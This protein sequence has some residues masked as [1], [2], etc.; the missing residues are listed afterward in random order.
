MS[1]SRRT[2]LRRGALAA[3]GA[4]CSPVLA[5]AAPVKKQ[6]W[7]IILNTVRNEMKVDYAGTL[8]KLAE[9]GYRYIEGGSYG[10]SEKEYGKLLRRLGLKPV[11][12]GS[13][14]SNLQESLPDYI[15]RGHA[16]NYEYITCYWPWLSSAENLTRDECLQAA[17][18]L[19]RMGRQLKGEGLRLAWHNHDKEFRP[20][21]DT[22][23]FDLLLQHTDPE[24]VTVQMDLYWVYKGGAD[25]LPYFDRYPGRFELFHVKDMDDSPERGITC[26]GEGIIDFQPIFDRAKEAGVRYSVV[27]HERVEAGLR[28]AEVSMEYLKSLKV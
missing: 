17:E 6:H 22:C 24:L 25:P 20:I 13:S 14:M 10:D 26:V 2:F 5:H 18:R 27:E 19:N 3:L 21:G 1:P 28:C 7:G 16:L 11:V 8:E 12:G 9:M 4:A 23:A 15:R